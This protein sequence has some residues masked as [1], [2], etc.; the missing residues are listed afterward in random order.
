MGVTIS[1]TISRKNKLPDLLNTKRSKSK[2]KLNLEFRNVLIHYIDSFHNY[3]LFNLKRITHNTDKDV[4][5]Y[6]D[7]YVEDICTLIANDL[8]DG[9]GH[10]VWFDLKN[11][12]FYFFVTEN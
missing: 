7:S 5:K 1:R 11:G 2:T 6:M 3:K 10:N 8:R 9:F 4:I 12:I